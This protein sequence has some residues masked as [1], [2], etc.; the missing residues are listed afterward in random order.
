MKRPIYVLYALLFN[1]FA[2]L[3]KIKKNRIALV[4]MHNE[5]FND[6]LG[7]IHQ[8]LKEKGGYEFVFITRQDLEVKVSNILHALSFFFVK[9]RLLATS[10]YVFLNDNFLPMSKCRFK[11]EAVITQLWHGEGVFKKFGLAIEQPEQV[12]QDEIKANGRLTYVVCSSKS[13]APFYAEA[14]GVDASR[15]ISAGSPRTDCFFTKSFIDRAKQNFY[16]LYPSLK[17][18]TL[19]LYAPTFRDD[20]K[21]NEQLLLHFD[22]KRF[23]RETDEN[24]DLL[25]R[26][27]PQIRPKNKTVEYA[28]DVT[29]YEDVREL[30]CVCDILI[31]DYSSICMDFSL[32]NK[33]TVFYAYDLEEYKKQRDFYFDYEKYVPGTVAK[34]FDEVISAVKSPFDPEKNGKFK[35]FNFDY[36][37]SGS[38]QRVIEAVIK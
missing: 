35:S 10:K 1:A 34:T 37:D 6:S 13:V 29:N 19:V 9:S 24:T 28:I 26:L 2:A 38:A 16:S 32:L 18:K 12:R 25:L 20:E 4:S 3:F 30:V 22:F 36:A 7:C 8:K 31:T 14:F 23:S 11:K 27:H 17:G 5:N 15:V 21:A 33:K